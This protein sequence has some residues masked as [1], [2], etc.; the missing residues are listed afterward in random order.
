MRLIKTLIILALILQSCGGSDDGAGPDTGGPGSDLQLGNFNLTFPNN[1]ELCIEGTDVSNTMI[2]IPFR[3][4]SSTNATSYKI[5]VT[6]TQDGKKY[7][8]T[9]DTNSTEIAIPKGNQFSWKV[10][11]LLEGKTKESNAIWNFY[12]QGTTTTAHIPFP[13]EI[14]LE[15]NKDGTINI[16]WKAIDL[17]NDIEKYEVYLSDATGTLNL[18]ADTQEVKLN[19]ISITYDI[20]YILEVITKD[21]NENTSLSKKTFR[22]KS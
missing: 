20:S 9:S 7:E 22:F 16:S 19:N 3:W 14:T 12:S 10:S 4:S 15:D 18:I 5:E 1:N 8:A 13:A 17:D 21:K 2:N 6:N 11:A